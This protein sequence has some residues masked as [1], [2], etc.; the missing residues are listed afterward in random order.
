MKRNELIFLHQSYE[1][2]KSVSETLKIRKMKGRMQKNINTDKKI[3][4]FL[5]TKKKVVCV[6]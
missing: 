6:G 5:V 3:L 4:H 1:R 2:E